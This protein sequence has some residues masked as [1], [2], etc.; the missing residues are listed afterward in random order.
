[1]YQT[2]ALKHITF[3]Q[4]QTISIWSLT[5]SRVPNRRIVPNKRA[6]MWDLFLDLLGENSLKKY[7][8]NLV[9]KNNKQPVRLFETTKA[10]MF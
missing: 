2:K 10:E 8:W 3:L 4:K 7:K 6:I 1:M 9:S 5:Y